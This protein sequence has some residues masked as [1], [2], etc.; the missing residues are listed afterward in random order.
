MMATT[1]TWSISQMDT[2]Q[3]PQPDYV[4]EVVWTLTAVDGQY[5]VNCSNTQMFNVTE[6]ET[7]VPYA[8]LTEAIVLGWV[9]DALGA[10]GVAA[11]EAQ[12]QWYIDRQINP[13]TELPQN[14]PLPWS[15]E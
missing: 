7:F 10:S 9:Q 15:Q 14:T 5:G 3:S 1:F 4:V 11:A 8:N 13:P 12:A 6:S 2:I